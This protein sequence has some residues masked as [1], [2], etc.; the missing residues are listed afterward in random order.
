[1]KKFLLA[2]LTQP[3]FAHHGQD[4]LVTL[5]S[6]TLAPWQALS[7][8]GFEHS[9]Y[10]DS[11]EL[12]FTQTFILGL[13]NDLSFGATFRFA[14]EGSGGWDD[15]SIT[16]SLQWTA[17]ALSLP[18]LDF[19]LHLSIAA[20]WEIPISTSSAH[21][22]GDKITKQDCRSLIAIPSLF[23]ACHQANASSQ[24]HTH[25]EGGHSHSGIHRHGESHGFLRFIGEISP[26]SRDRLAVNLI[27][28]FPEDDSIQ[29]GYALAYRRQ[30]NDSF[31]LGLEFTGDF[32]AQGEHLAY[33][34]S[35]L[36][37]NH[38]LTLTLGAAAGLSSA[39]PSHSFQSLLVWR[40]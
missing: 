32:D 24:S 1:M 11:E 22:H 21:V 14:E 26:S 31:S 25:D 40:F 5:D 39:S 9:R 15:F 6:K 8:S 19:T 2:L 28:V 27:A 13:P 10:T 12:S 23:A 20:G 3:V 33:L 7:G 4:F 37:L 30:L 36:F 16:P 17:P 18:A 35:T 34:T 38:H 29:T